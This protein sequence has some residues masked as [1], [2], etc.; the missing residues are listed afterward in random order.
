M[1]LVIGIL[2]V[3][4]ARQR[5][6][7]LHGKIDDPPVALMKSVGLAIDLV[8]QRILQMLELQDAADTLHGDLHD[9]RLREEVHGARGE[10]SRFRVRFVVGSQEYHRQVFTSIDVANPLQNFQAVHAGH[11]QIE[12]HEAGLLLFQLRESF[13]PGRNAAH[14]V[15][16]AEQCFNG[17]QAHLVVVHREDRVFFPHEQSLLHGG[18][19][20][21]RVRGFSDE[22]QRAETDC[23]RHVRSMG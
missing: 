3:D 13:R 15:S 1:V 23:L 17:Q 10:Q 12:Q 8:V 6:N 18:K 2:R 19:K 4:G 20:I 7:D 21:F 5:V 22:V 11:S 9:Q 16:D 14:V